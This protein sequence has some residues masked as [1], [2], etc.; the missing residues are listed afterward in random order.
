MLSVAP[1]GASTYQFQD[2]LGS[3]IA[4]ANA[5]GQVTEKY[6]YTAYGQTV[7]VVPAPPSG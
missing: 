5:S 6:A 7:S 4:L 2:A 3:V 1:G